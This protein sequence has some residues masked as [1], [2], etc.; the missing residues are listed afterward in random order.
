MTT[1]LSSDRIGGCFADIDHDH[2]ALERQ[3]TILDQVLAVRGVRLGILR[4]RLTELS[5]VLQAHFRKEE[6]EG[7]FADIVQLAP[8]LSRQAD[9]LEA[10]HRTLLGQLS[11]LRDLFAAASEFAPVPFA[12]RQAFADFVQACRDHEHRETE[13]VQDAW[14]TELGGGD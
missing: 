1:V 7:Y 3:Y 13:L 2:H 11:D 12:L 6:R 14:L 10:E 4:G 8:R 9:A 5:D